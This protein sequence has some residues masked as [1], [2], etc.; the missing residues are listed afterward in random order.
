MDRA[1][2]AEPYSNATIWTREVARN[3]AGH[4]ARI[5]NAHSSIDTRSPKATQLPHFTQPRASKRCAT[6]PTKV[7]QPVSVLAKSIEDENAISSR[8]EVSVTKNNTGNQPLEQDDPSTEPTRTNETLNGIRSN[9]HLAHI[10]PLPGKPRVSQTANTRSRTSL[11]RV[12][13]SGSGQP[14]L[15]A[16][17]SDSMY[18]CP[19]VFG[20]NK[21]RSGHDYNK[22]QAQLK[23]W[24][25]NQVRTRTM[26]DIHT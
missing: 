13:S 18:D 25:E 15:L 2:R 23:I 26:H 22:K 12:S 6:S 24:Q 1:R 4:L 8:E 21:T 14:T 9:R 11:D 17:A 7:Q 16:P 20:N 5:S 3:L 19:P 10:D